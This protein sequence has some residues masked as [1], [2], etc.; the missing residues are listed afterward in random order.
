VNVQLKNY[1]LYTFWVSAT[2]RSVS[3]LFFRRQSHID[4][5]PGYELVTSRADF[6]GL[7]RDFAVNQDA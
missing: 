4:R 3:V 5:A 2:L 1:R 6:E 7:P